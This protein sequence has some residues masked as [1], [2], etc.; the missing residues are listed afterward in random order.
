LAKAAGEMG[1]NMILPLIREEGFTVVAKRNYGIAINNPLELLEGALDSMEGK[2]GHCIFQGDRRS[3][4]MLRNN[5]VTF[6]RV[7]VNFEPL[8]V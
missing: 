6:P 8:Y 3:C 4:R 1:R 2:P 7:K 5:I